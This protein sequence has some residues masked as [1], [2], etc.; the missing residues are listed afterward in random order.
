MRQPKRRLPWFSLFSLFAGLFCLLTS[1]TAAPASYADRSQ[2]SLQVAQTYFDAYIAR[3]WDRLAEHLAADGQFSDPTAQAVFGQVGA[4]GKEALLAYF[5]TNYAGITQMSFKPLRVVSASDHV[6]F[7][8]TLDWD[9]RLPN[10]TVVPT[11]KMPFLTILR[12]Q[13]GQVVDHQDYADYGPF[14]TAHRLATGAQR[15]RTRTP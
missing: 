6:I 8:G 12:L 5:R 1:A 13:D 10:G 14:V 4:Q 11:R 15:D 3:D 2:A 7:E 9:L